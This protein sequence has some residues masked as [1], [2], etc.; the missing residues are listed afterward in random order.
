MNELEKVNEIKDV[1]TSKE[2]LEQINYFRS[3]QGIKTELAHSDLLKIV[4]D[5]FEE[6]I[7][8]GKFSL[9]EY[10][11]KKGEM[12]P[13]YN[14]TLS[15]AKQVLVR[16]SKVV[17]K[18]VI[19][20]INKLEQALSQRQ[21]PT[22][23]IAALEQLITT[24]KEKQALQIENNEMK[25]KAEFYDAVTGSNTVCDIGT[26]AKLLNIGM[27]R[28]KLFEMLR[29]RKI[30]QSDN[31][32]YQR[33]C[34]DGKFRIIESKYQLPNGDTQVYFKTVVTQKGVDYIRKVLA[35]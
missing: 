9:V 22:D 7:N 33:H 6:E 28:N 8:E 1:I 11:D 29:S 5:E 30:L 12:R 24:A 19:S 20:Y 27:G 23:Y 26:L 16:E 17:R 31:K 14:L 35:A 15:Q 10:K 3:Q 21:L 13:M 25:P 34:D 18:A 4:R 2:L 32:P